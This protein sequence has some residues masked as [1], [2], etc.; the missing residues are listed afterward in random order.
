MK[1]KYMEPVR[2]NKGFYKGHVGIINAVSRH[3]FKTRYLITIYTD[4]DATCEWIPQ[5]YLEL[6]K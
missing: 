1:F 5:C 3:F 6:K 2:I 4:T